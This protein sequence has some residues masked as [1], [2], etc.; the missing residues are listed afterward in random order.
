[1]LS[2]AVGWQIYRLTGSALSLG[3]VGLA[4]FIPM[5]C[6]TLLV[7]HV[8]D[9][10]ERRRI[11]ALCMA[12]EALAAGVL[13]LG[14]FWQF[15]TPAL[16]FVLV[17]VG[18]VGRAFESPTQATLLPALVPRVQLQR[19]TAL[20]TSCNQTAQIVGPAVGGAV[21]ALNP[22][23]AFALAALLMAL[24]AWLI[25]RLRLARHPVSREP[26]TLASI[27]S[28]IAF[29]RSRPVMLGTISL[30]LFAVLLG[31]ATA[32][33]PIFA[34]D[35][36]AVGPG[37]L[38]ALRAAPALGALSMSL[39]MARHP[40][41]GR[42]G[43]TLFGA[44]ICFGAA[45]LTFALSRDF[46]LSLAALVVLGASDS[47]S[48]IIRTTLVQ[49]QTPDHMLG[50]VSAVN[51]LFVGA[52]NQLG[53]FESGLSASLLGTVPAAALGGI[54][55]I[56]VSLLWMHLFPQLRRM[57]SLDGR[58]PESLAEGRGPAQ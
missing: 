41:R 45:T 31:G 16:I 25:F 56:A 3:L 54:G 27:F 55:T 20:S 30:D 8:A 48:V 5:V 15:L 23:C 28:G 22:G 51:M 29:I 17:V 18:S 43:R 37:G 9:R 24:G 12:L 36:L 32:L 1:M 13:A 39:F 21:Y 7:G 4:Q 53:E 44:L 57:R 19:A 33:L 34:K 26:A 35:I 38:G 14:V 49:L 52:S 58:E 2:V 42:I 11:V 50:R 46:L 40:L 10:F 6:L 47:I